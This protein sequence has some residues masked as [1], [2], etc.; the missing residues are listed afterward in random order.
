MELP[1]TVRLVTVRGQPTRMPFCAPSRHRPEFVKDKHPVR[2]VTR[3]VVDAGEFRVAPRVGDSFQVSVLWKALE[4][5]PVLDQQ[6]P[7][8]FPPDLERAG[9]RAG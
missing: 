4:G 6:L 5:D 7:Q 8:P 9:G 3:H 1:D 2:E